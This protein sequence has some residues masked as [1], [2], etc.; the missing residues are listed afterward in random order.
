MVRLSSIIH[1][2]L[3]SSEIDICPARRI[4]YLLVVIS[5]EL[6]M[7]FKIL[8]TFFSVADIGDKHSTFDKLEILST[9]YSSGCGAKAI[10]FQR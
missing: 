8:L 9:L 1:A 5:N 10:A 2:L 6:S 7:S 3:E 4:F